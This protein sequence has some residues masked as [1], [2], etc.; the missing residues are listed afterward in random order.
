M[1]VPCSSAGCLREHKLHT[2]HTTA[3]TLIQ[4][5][6]G[7]DCLQ[8]CF[9]SLECGL[10]DVTVRQESQPAVQKVGEREVRENFNAEELKTVLES[11]KRLR[12]LK[13][14]NKLTEESP[15]NNNNKKKQ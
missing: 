11:L 14:N 8:Q 5:R 4:D 1:H 2:T 13:A 3:L 6:F 12:Q 9:R 15:E 7:A 10:R